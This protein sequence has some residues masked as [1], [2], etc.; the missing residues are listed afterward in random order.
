MAVGGLEGKPVPDHPQR[1]A[2]THGR[3]GEPGG[4]LGHTER[5]RY[6]RTCE[7]G[8]H[9]RRRGHH[10]GARVVQLCHQHRWRVG[11][12]HPGHQGAQPDAAG[13]ARQDS[14]VGM[15]QQGETAQRRRDQPT[16]D[17]C[18]QCHQLPHRGAPLLSVYC[19]LV[20]WR[21][22]LSLRARQDSLARH[23]GHGAR[24]GAAQQGV[25]EE[26]AVSHQGGEDLRQ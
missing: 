10:G 26:D 14:Q 16:G 5:H 24:G 11:E 17:G 12:E 3:S 23:R 9:L 20:H 22:R 2:G 7:V 18:K 4:R 21:F 19:R 1:V 6:R 8:V 15:A 13:H 25:H